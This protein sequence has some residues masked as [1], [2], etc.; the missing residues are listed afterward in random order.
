[1]TA[2]TTRPAGSGVRRCPGGAAGRGLARLLLLTGAAG[3]LAGGA[4]A[5]VVANVPMSP[6]APAKRAHPVL[7][8][9]RTALDVDEPAP[10]DRA[11]Y[12]NTPRP[13]ASPASDELAPTRL[14]PQPSWVTR[15]EAAWQ[16]RY[17]S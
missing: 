6:E 13:E 11:L 2:R 8:G 15:I 9:D 7:W 5:M 1:M 12:Q 3:A 14:E 16:R 10:A 17:A 4:G